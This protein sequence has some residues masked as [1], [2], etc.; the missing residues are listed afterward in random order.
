[1]AIDYSG[2]CDFSRRRY[3][4]LHQRLQ[5]E[6]DRNAFANTHGHQISHGENERFADRFAHCQNLTHCFADSFSS[7][8]SHGQRL[9]DS[10]AYRD[11]VIN[12]SNLN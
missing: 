12:E 3:L 5:E 8:F 1:M 7:C 11:A 4:L 9:A 10:F 6:Y 2:D